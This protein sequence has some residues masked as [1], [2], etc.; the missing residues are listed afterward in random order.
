M[1]RL[2]VPFGVRSWQPTA[3]HAIMYRA[4]LHSS[5]S[6]PT[7]T[8]LSTVNL[9]DFRRQLANDSESRTRA[10]LNRHN[11]QILKEIGTTIANGRSS[12]GSGGMTA[13]VLIFVLP[14]LLSAV[15]YTGYNT[16]KGTPTFLPVW[17]QKKFP[18]SEV[19]NIEHVDLDVLKKHTEYS[20][21]EKLSLD[22]RIRSRFGL[23]LQMGE[24]EQFDVYV[25]FHD[26]GCSGLQIDPINRFPPSFKWI[27]KEVVIHDKFQNIL[28]PMSVGAQK[29][30][31]RRDDDKFN[32]YENNKEKKATSKRDYNIV[33]YGRVPL[34]SINSAITDGAV[35]FTG[36]VEFDHTKTV[37]IKNVKLIYRVNGNVKIEP[38]W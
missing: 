21:L 34:N 4:L 7:M 15:L 12:R 8:R 3:S 36:I 23:P 29:G 6:G 11:D 25:E 14:A 17:F 28:E 27:T 38:L 26:Y 9:K 24:L 2:S 19:S 22:H 1:L 32:I 13:V 35:T 20:V 10:P 37:K 30:I 31:G 5:R 16:Y 18:I 33:V